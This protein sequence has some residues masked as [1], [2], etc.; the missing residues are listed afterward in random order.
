MNNDE[1]PRIA[2]PIFD[3]P[4]TRAYLR[5]VMNAPLATIAPWVTTECPEC[6]GVEGYENLHT[7]IGKIV[8]IGCEGYFVINPNA[9]GIDSPNWS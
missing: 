8:L 7:M 1:L 3:T 4:K 6:C 5:A 9:V 2:D